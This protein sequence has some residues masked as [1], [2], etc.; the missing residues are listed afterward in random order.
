VVAIAAAHGGAPTAAR[1]AEQE[2]PLTETP[3][4]GQ[5]GAR[6]QAPDGKDGLAAARERLAG[7]AAGGPVLAAVHGGTPLTRILL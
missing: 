7:L 3:Q 4:G 1:A 2:L 6:L 5:W